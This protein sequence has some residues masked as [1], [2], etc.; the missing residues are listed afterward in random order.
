MSLERIQ[1]IYCGAC[2]MPLEYCDYGPDFETHCNPWLKKNHPTLFKEYHRSV[3]AVDAADAADEQDDKPPRPS[4]P[5][6]IEER[7]TAFYEKYEPDKVGNV[8]SLLEKYTGKE[9]K[10]FVAL[11]KKYGDEPIDPYY[12]YDDDDEEEDFEE[13]IAEQTVDK[14]KRRGAGAKK[15]A[16]QDTR[17]VI[18]KITRNRKKATTVLVGM[19]TVP[20]LK[21]KDAAKSFAKRFA[22]S[23]SV[24]GKEIII[25]GDH[26]DAV[27]QMVVSQFKVPGESVYLDIDGDFVQFRSV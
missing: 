1:P 7:L 26:M 17:V 20:D 13:S 3:A 14:K 4:A 5:W 12:E 9:D 24:K 23:S 21:L 18:Q 8:P 27:A 25:Q 19:D 22:G 6:T 15:T 16:K 11:V 10:L 2:G